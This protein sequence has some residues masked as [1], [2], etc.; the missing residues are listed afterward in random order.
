MQDEKKVAET[1]EVVRRVMAK[2][3]ARLR[4]SLKE[5]PGSL[6]EIELDVD[7]LGDMIKQEITKEMVDRLGDGYQGTRISCQQCSGKARF[8][9]QRD[10]EII[11]L[12]GRLR[13]KRAYYYCARCRWSWS[14][15]DRQLDLGSDDCSRMVCSLAA[16]VASYLPFGVAAEELR[17]LRRIDI[18]A[19]TVQRQAKKV[20]ARMGRKWDDLL[21]LAALGQ[22]PPSEIYPNR[23]FM[24]MDAAKCHVGGRWRDA[25]L[26]AV[27]H[28]SDDGRIEYAQ[29]YASLDQSVDFGP[30]MAML[31]HVAG[32]DNCDDHQMLGDGAEWIWFETGKHAPTA[33]QTLDMFHGC[34]YLQ[35]FAK[36]RYGEGG[37]M[38]RK[39]VDAQKKCLLYG[40]GIEAV[41]QEVA[42]WRPRSKAGG[43]VKRTTLNYL[44]AH[45]D[46][47]NYKELREK[48]YDIGS[49]LIES[50]CK[51][52]I[53][54]RIGGA[55]MRWEHDGASAVLHLSAFWRGDQA[56]S[57]LQYT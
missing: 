6:H 20:G 2:F 9:G 15:V 48:G 46:R 38:A 25:K 41:L 55:G 31:A 3:E 37:G 36:A 24:A 50:G 1:E 4:E 14:P 27:Y 56:A 22:A 29:Y 18:S 42:A 26:G 7:N 39:W 23:L 10:R 49:G 44:T 19:T 5:N 32:G 45:R 13:Y 40:D 16:R 47:M 8:Y 30:R 17:A 12:H 21:A 34:E 53:K 51:A 35:T 54:A 52:V 57:F 11:T 28:R 33:I 43:E